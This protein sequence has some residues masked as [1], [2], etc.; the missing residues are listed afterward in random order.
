MIN[1]VIAGSGKF[2]DYETLEVTCNSLIGHLPKD[3]VTI[4][5]GAR[6]EGV[7][8]LAV[9]YAEKNGYKN[10]EEFPADWD[11]YKKAAG[12]IRNKRMAEKGD[13]V[14]VFWN[15]YSKGSWNMIQEAL[16]YGCHLFV[17]NDKI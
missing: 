8:A 17:H 16:G 2:K 3:N 5:H 11:S 14:I 7:D 13:M 9:E 10:I 12:P 6:P 15:G 4:I 1:V